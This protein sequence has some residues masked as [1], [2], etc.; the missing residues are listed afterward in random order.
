MLLWDCYMRHST[1]MLLSYLPVPLFPASLFNLWLFLTVFL[2]LSSFLPLSHYDVLFLALLTAFLSLFCLFV[3]RMGFNRQVLVRDWLN[4]FH[5][6]HRSNQLNRKENDSRCSLFC[7]AFS[8]SFC[9]CFSELQKYALRFIQSSHR[10]HDFC[11]K[12]ATLDSTKCWIIHWIKCP[13]SK[14]VLIV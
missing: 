8:A 1:I 3:L 6:L 4:V 11:V 12:A 10:K 9:L 5:S 13:Q 14:Y 2:P 7:W